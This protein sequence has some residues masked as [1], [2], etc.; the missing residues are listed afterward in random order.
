MT[1]RRFV[2]SIDE[3][4]EP[5]KEEGEEAEA[6]GKPDTPTTRWVSASKEVRETAKW[7]IA[8][9]G[10]VGG[11]VF[12]GGPFLSKGELQGVLPYIGVI[13]S[14][15]VGAGG[16]AYLIAR[17]AQ[18]LLPY[19]VT[20]S[21][22]PPNLLQM[23]ARTPRAFLPDGLQTVKAFTERLVLFDQ[24][25]RSMPPKAAAMKAA[26]D[27]LPDNT[28]EERA[29]KARGCEDARLFADAAATVTR[30]AEIYR[31]V[32]SDLL[33]Q[34]EY[35]QVSAKFT[36]KS[37]FMVAAGVAVAVSAAT[38]LAL[39]SN[40][41]DDDSEAGATPAAP[42]LGLLVKTESEASTELWMSAGLTPCET[43][44][45]LGEGQDPSTVVP[46]LV[47]SG[48]GTVTDPYDVTTLGS[49]T[50]PTGP[51]CGVVTFSTI[52]DVAKIVFP[53]TEIT[54]TYTVTTEQP[55]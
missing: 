2:V 3:D 23:I 6:A 40:T 25:S 18:V 43:V 36:G 7:V 29:K 46:V 44:V 47:R 50:V 26:A 20:L 54:I 49:A 52:D 11:A 15:A 4:S 1:K 31:Q 17:T 10:A 13:V 34:A 8:T 19:R 38:Y 12:A 16:L 24:L 55:N 35:L 32:R 21:S 48:S 53:E 42:R 14:A 28:E 41:S 39:W 9:A 27:A 5:A 33:D 45:A 30:N 37:G 51:A 22:L